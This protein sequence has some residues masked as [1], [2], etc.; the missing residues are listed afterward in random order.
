MNKSH[1]S[2][3]SGSP[4]DIAGDRGS[5][6]DPRYYADGVRWEEDTYRTLRRSRSIAWAI[7]GV[8]G[9][10]TMLSLSCLALLLPLKQF[11]PY[12][13]TVDRS[14]GYLEVSRALK[15]GDLSQDEAITAAN[16][17]R[18]LKARETYDPRMLKDNYD[19]AQLLSAESASKDLQ[20]LYAP[21]NQ[22]SPDRVYGR[23]TVVAVLIKNVSF[24]NNH[25][26][27]VRFQT[28]ERTQSRSTVR[29]WVSVIK[30]RYV[31]APMKN[32]WRFDNPL[33]F[34]VVEYRRDQETVPAAAGGASG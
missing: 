30:F 18:F 23:D 6:V 10:T 14:T 4:D 27:T 25:T 20:D 1:Y 9:A 2:D 29:H 3:Q 24:L 19:L 16:L 34:Q 22:Q 15:P 7:T 26:A 33:G 31:G 12:V 21:S 13:V 8:F 11:E 28:E 5:V 17:V 32:E